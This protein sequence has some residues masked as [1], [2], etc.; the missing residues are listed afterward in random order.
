MRN[1]SGN[2]NVLGRLPRLVTRPLTIASERVS[3]IRPDRVQDRIVHALQW[4]RTALGLTATVWLVMAYPMKVGREDFVMGK[5]EDLLISCGIT[6]GVGLLAVTAFI[7]AARAPLGRR[8]ASCLLGPGYCVVMILC[9]AGLCWLTWKTLRG[10]LFSFDIV[11][12]DQSWLI[13][14]LLVVGQGVG[15]LICLILLLCA[16]PFTVVV[17]V[18]GVNSCF[19]LG[20]VHDL[21]PALLSPLMVWSLFILNFSDGPDVAAPPSILY[22]FLLGGP[23]SVT[24]L[25]VWETYRLRRRYGLTLR[26]ALGR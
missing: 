2:R 13:S 7:S 3:S 14:V 4:S 9:G 17:L 10:E 18:Y 8:Y 23:V 26:T 19:R 25:S 15:G 22:T 1:M 24:L 21:L 5:L 11:P 20:D 16:I 6:F 12:G